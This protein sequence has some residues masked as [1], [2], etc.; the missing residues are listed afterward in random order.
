MPLYEYQCEK[1]GRITEV[2]AKSTSEATEPHKCG[3]GESSHFV[4]LYSTFAAHG[5]PAQPEFA[6]CGRE[7]CH[8]DGS[9]GRHA[10]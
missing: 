6:G 8:G 9:C 10:L 4:K 2:L 1:C 5:G 7:G 3:C